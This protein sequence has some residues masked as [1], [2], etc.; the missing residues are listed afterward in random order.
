MTLNS[1]SKFLQAA[2]KIVKEPINTF[3]K[4]LALESLCL[5]YE[6]NFINVM[7]EEFKDSENSTA[8]SAMIFGLF[9]KSLP[10]VIEAVE[11]IVNTAEDDGLKDFKVDKI[12]SGRAKLLIAIYILTADTVASIVFSNLVRICG[13][14][15]GG[16]EMELI[17]NISEAIFINMKHVKTVSHKLPRAVKA[18]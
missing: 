7:L 13:A 6:R 1:Q 4:Q 8:A 18:V 17:N 2:L 16:E 9:N 10:N 15:G 5:Y 14:G 11:A 3:E 12:L